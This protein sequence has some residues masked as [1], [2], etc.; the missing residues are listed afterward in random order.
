MGSGMAFPWKLI[1][2]ADLATAHIVEDIVLGIQLCLQGSP[3]LF[4]RGVNVTSELPRSVSGR[5]Q[6]RARWIHGHLMVVREYLPKLLGRALARLDGAAL[7]MAADLLIPP[8]GLLAL[9]AGLT[10]IAALCW[11]VVSDQ[12]L[13][14]GLAQAAVVMFVITMLIAWVLAGRDLIRSSELIQLVTH[15][16]VTGRIAGAFWLGRKSGWTRTERN[17]TD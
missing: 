17:K 10:W 2:N 8:M 3:P 12:L 5:E 6:Q 1:A 7:A 15:V 4:Y 14:F 13:P 16:I 11:Y 9:A